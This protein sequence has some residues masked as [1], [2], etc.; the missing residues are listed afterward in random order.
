[1]SI[2]RPLLLTLLFPLTAHTQTNPTEP[3][4]TE[5][6][7][8]PELTLT[9]LEALL[10]KPDNDNIPFDS[11]KTFVDVFDTIKKYYVNEVSNQE[12]I[13]NAIQGMLTR[14]DPHSAYLSE[15]QYH[16][17]NLTS[18][19]EYAGIGVVLDLKA[20][21]MQIVSAIEG[22]PADKAGLKSGDIIS[23]VDGQNVIDLTLSE[24]AKLMSGEVGSNVKLTILRD[25][26]IQEFQFT[27][28]LIA[29]N[30]VSSR[31]IDN[32]HAIIRLTQFQ[33]DTAQALEKEIESLSI[34]YTLKGIILDLRNNPGGL[35]NP[36]IDSSD[37]FLNEGLILTIR[38]RDNSQSEYFHAQQGDILNGRPIV[39]LVNQGS[40]SGAEI[41]AGALRDNHRA[42]IVGQTTF[43]KGSVQSI[44]P[45]FHGGAVK[46]TTARYY[47]PSGESIQAQGIIP[48]VALTPLN[49]VEDKK[50]TLENQR[51]TALPNHLQSPNAGALYTQQPLS[52]KELAQTDFTLYEA[53]NILK[54]LTLLQTNPT[55]ANLSAQPRAEAPNAN[56]SSPS[57]PLESESANPTDSLE[58][59]SSDMSEALNPS[60]SNDKTTP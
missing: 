43:G 32:D 38:G 15:A 7:A 31:M 51:E 41:M 1:M 53:L 29:T 36:A 9:S 24:T 39:V 16:D 23:Q 4:N 55:S 57:K 33:E 6:T 50:E 35:L 20:G 19:G 3:P 26:L 14:L 42:I 8:T 49:V 10:Q 60:I 21:S 47:T 40:A 28:E 52:D 2:I 48:Q 37:L 11:L 30:S 18:D 27:R 22:S 46:M 13:D 56:P 25:N 34:K 54:T 59:E 17:F 58:N 45:L 5:S 44:T 12:L